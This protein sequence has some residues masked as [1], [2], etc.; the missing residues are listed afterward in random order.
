MSVVLSFSRLANVLFFSIRWH[1]LLLP[2][3]N[4]NITVTFTHYRRPSYYPFSCYLLSVLFVN[5][6]II[7]LS[8]IIPCYSCFVIFFSYLFV[9]S[10]LSAAVL[11]LLVLFFLSAVRFCHLSNELLPASLSCPLPPCATI[12]PLFATYIGCLLF[13]PL[14]FCFVLISFYYSVY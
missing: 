4:R 6:L 5:A 9:S 7:F 13:S 8:S 12:I 2:I 10:I 11:W 14:T 1:V 3:R